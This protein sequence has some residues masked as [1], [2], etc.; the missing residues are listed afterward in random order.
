[1]NKLLNRQVRRHFGKH[2]DSSS[3]SK[4]ILALLED[5]SS[6]YNELYEEK[7]FLEHTIGINSQDLEQAK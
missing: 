6:S 7:K 3:F 5:V 2:F 1:M 4:E